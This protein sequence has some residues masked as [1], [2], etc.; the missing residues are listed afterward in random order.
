VNGYEALV[1]WYDRGRPKS[2]EK[3][4][5]QCYFVHQKFNV[6]W[7]GAEPGPLW[8]TACGM[9][10]LIDVWDIPYCTSDFIR[11]PNKLEECKD[12]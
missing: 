7:P 3:N 5:T 9:D 11:R 10:W 2:S 12:P 6:V 8:L 1:G 4:L